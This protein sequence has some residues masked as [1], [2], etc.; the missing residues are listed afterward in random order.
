MIVLVLDILQLKKLAVTIIC[1]EG[2]I[3]NG[4]PQKLYFVVGL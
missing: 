4:L 3:N 2:F 1:T